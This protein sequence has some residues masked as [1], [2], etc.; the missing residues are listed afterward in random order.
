MAELLPSLFE[1]KAGNFYVA[2]A[3]EADRVRVLRII[4]QYLKPNQ[5]VFVGVIATIDPRIETPEE[6]RDL[7]LEAADYIPVEQLGTTDDCGFSPFC[8]RHVH[9][10]R[11]GVREDPLASRW[12]PA[13][14]RG[15]RSQVTC[16]E[17]RK[18]SSS[19]RSRSRTRRASCS[20]ASGP[21]RS[22]FVRSRRWNARRRNSARH[23]RPRGTGSWSRTREGTVTDF[24]PSYVE[25]WRLP[26]DVV[27]TMDHR[28]ILEHLGRQFENSAAVPFQSR[29]DLHRVARREPGCARAGRWKGVRTVFHARES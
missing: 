2:L 1:L 9:Q 14:L 11:H 28:R 24:N 10:P 6:V 3:G 12:H 20:P 27:D 17:T 8:R 29:G 23:S 18:R 13:R 26:P 15:D 22:C 16:R 19:A 25:M 4:R 5:R 21:S 7:I